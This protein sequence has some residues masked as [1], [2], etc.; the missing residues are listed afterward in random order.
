MCGE[1]AREGRLG[2]KIHIGRGRAAAASVAFD[3][4]VGSV[5]RGLGCA[6]ALGDHAS[7]GCLVFALA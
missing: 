2:P 1:R 3:D 4:V 7:R 6:I 5:Y